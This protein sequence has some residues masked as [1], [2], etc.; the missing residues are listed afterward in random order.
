MNLV[1]THPRVLVNGAATP[2]GSLPTPGPAGIRVSDCWWD[3]DSD[4]SLQ[5]ILL[6]LGV[7]SSIASDTS[8]S[9]SPD[10]AFPR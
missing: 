3:A 2:P 9:S 8:V 6:Y 1:M 7:S 4:E 5:T 10:R